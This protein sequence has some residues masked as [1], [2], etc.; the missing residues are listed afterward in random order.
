MN[1]K[2][3]KYLPNSEKIIEYINSIQFTN[4]YK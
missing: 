1:F 3:F 4:Y 2:D